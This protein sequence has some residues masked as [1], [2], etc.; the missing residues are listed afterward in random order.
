MHELF[1]EMLTRDTRNGEGL[2]LCLQWVFFAIEPLTP[3]ELYSAVLTGV[4][5]DAIRESDMEDLSESDFDRY[6]LDCSKGL[7]ETTKS[8]SRIA[9]FIHES[10]RDFLLKDNGFISLVANE[11]GHSFDVVDYEKLKECY[12]VQMEIARQA[13]ELALLPA[14]FPFLSL[15]SNMP[16]TTSFAILIGQRNLDHPKRNS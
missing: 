5:H 9:Q 3:A 12:L 6:I 1:R 2:V 7:I 10:V 15:F 14:K 8:A 13:N 4:D 11:K 16:S